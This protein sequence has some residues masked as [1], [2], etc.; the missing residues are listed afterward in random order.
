MGGTAE[1]DTVKTIINNEL[2]K[3]EDIINKETDLIKSEINSENEKILILTSKGE[4][5]GNE[6]DVEKKDNI[7]EI[8]GMEISATNNNIKVILKE[9]SDQPEWRNHLRVEEITG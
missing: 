1:T 6:C 2:S 9:T 8:N 4:N 5:K 3:K 7:N